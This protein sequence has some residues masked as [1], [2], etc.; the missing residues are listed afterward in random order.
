MPPR[1][2]PSAFQAVTREMVSEI[3]ASVS[4]INGRIGKLDDKVTILFNHQ[5]T[6]L[7]FWASAVL[8]TLAAACGFLLRMVIGGS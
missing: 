6:R 1:S 3:K 8:T 2:N 4:E 5:S 7:P